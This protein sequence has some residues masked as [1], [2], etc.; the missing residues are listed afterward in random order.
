MQHT[1]LLAGA[2]TQVH[3]ELERHEEIARRLAGVRGS[4]AWQVKARLLREEL[5][6]LEAAERRAGGAG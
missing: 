3:A 1:N 4:T 6:L 5:Y 2:I